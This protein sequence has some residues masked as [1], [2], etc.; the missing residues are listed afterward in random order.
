MAEGYDVININDPGDLK[1]LLKE[2]MPVLIVLGESLDFEEYLEFNDLK[3]LATDLNCIPMISLNI[4]HPKTKS[5]SALYIET[6]ILPE[7]LVRIGMDHIRNRQSLN[8]A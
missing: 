3:E 8:R 6:P 7:E 2:E 4:S 1:K 5:D